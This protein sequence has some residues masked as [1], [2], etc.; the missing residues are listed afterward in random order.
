VFA[1]DPNGAT[2][3]Q[4]S[5]NASAASIT[6]NSSLS[7]TSAA[8]ANP[9][10][11]ATGATSGTFVYSPPAGTVLPVGNAQQLRVAF[12]PN[13]TSD[14]NAAAKIVTIG[15]IRAATSHALRPPNGF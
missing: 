7:F 6:V 10:T 2:G 14:H 13:D 4:W 9:S 5:R 12:A 1:L 3:Q 8:A 15:V 11:V